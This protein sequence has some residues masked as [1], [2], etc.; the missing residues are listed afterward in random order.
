MLPPDDHEDFRIP[1]KLL[2]YQKGREILAITEKIVSLIEE[3]DEILSSLKEYMMLDAAQ[4]TVKV[5]GAEAADLYDLRMENATIIRKAA[6]DLQAHLSSLKM[7]GYKD[8]QYFH[9][10]RDAIE[11]YRVLFVEWV[12]GFDPWNY[13]PDRWGLFNPPGI[14]PQDGDDEGY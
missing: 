13:T 10:L 3:D 2:L 6:R 8:I 7:F 14:Q 12:Q 4:L 1:E 5:A 11:D 9:L